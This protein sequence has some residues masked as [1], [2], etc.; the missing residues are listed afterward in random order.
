MTPQLQAQMMAANHF[1]GSQHNV[2]DNEPL[3]GGA[4]NIEVNST[5]RMAV[6]NSSQASLTLAD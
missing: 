3:A 1:M 5:G 2:A 4:L 6:E